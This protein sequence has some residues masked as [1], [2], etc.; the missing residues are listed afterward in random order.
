VR[1]DE[2]DF[3]AIMKT[4]ISSFAFG[5]S[6]YAGYG[7]GGYTVE[8]P[9][10]SLGVLID[11]PISSQAVVSLVFQVPD[12]F[13]PGYTGIAVPVRAREFGLFTQEI[14]DLVIRVPAWRGSGW[15]ELTTPLFCESTVTGTTTAN[16][17]LTGV[18]SLEYDGVWDQFTAA[19]ILDPITSDA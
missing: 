5:G 2:G 10:P 8:F 18:R 6:M 9:S 14:G 4:D 17:T 19:A 15:H 7:T 12:G 11:N 16:F 13:T 1:A 3:A